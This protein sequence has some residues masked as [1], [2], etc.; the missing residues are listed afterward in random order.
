[1]RS[2]S[3]PPR[4]ND[5]TRLPAVIDRLGGGGGTYSIFMNGR[6]RMTIPPCI[7][8]MPGRSTSGFHRPGRHRLHQARSA[9][10][11]S[12]S[13][14]K[15]DLHPSEHR[16][17]DALRHLVPTFLFMDDSANESP[18]FLV[19]PLQRQQWV[20]LCNC[21]VGALSFRDM[22]SICTMF[23]LQTAPQKRGS[24]SKSMSIRCGARGMRRYQQKS[25][26]RATT[27]TKTN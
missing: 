1:M 5:P 3:Y 21:L 26:T 22:S 8:T 10:R 24:S 17:Q 6:S 15:G 4:T 27:K 14:M 9:V 12:A 20:L 25:N 19:W 2:K 11:C 18:C 13:R 23:N 7:P 16:S